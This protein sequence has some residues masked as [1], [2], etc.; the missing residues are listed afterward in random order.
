MARR[1][2]LAAAVTISAAAAGAS[3]FLVA[4]RA[5]IARVDVLASLTLGTVLAGAFPVRIPS[6]RVNVTATHAFV[7]CALVV[8]G[9][10]AAI[11][12]DAIGVI[13]AAIGRRSWPKSN[14][15]LFNLSNAVLSTSGAALAF[16]FAG[17]GLGRPLEQLIEPFGAAAVAYFLINACLVSVVVSIERALPLSATF[18]GACL[19]TG[20]AYFAGLSAAVAMVAVCTTPFPW[21]LAVGLP[22]AWA[23]TVLHRSQAREFAAEN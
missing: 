12:I 10:L 2:I 17:G 5:D 1:H 16:S 7:L 23:A 15:L 6:R 11:G 18:A 19:M 9:P 14:H 8:C 3:L 4:S 21:L 13:S 22:P 20:L